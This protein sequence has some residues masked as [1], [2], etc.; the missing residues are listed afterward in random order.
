M[1]KDKHFL[2]RSVA[3]LYKYTPGPAESSFGT[4]VARV[5]GVPESIVDFA[6]TLALKFEN[7]HTRNEEF[8]AI[9]NHSNIA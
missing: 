7:I 2:H 9:I 3:M 8:T 4:N 1:A 5:A 6:M